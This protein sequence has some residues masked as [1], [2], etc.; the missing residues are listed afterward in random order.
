MEFQT[1]GRVFL[2]Y[3]LIY[4]SKSNEV[5]HSP[6][7]GFVVE[8]TIPFFSTQGEIF[9]SLVH[10]FPDYWNLYNRSVHCGGKD[11]Y[12]QIRQMYNTIVSELPEEYESTLNGMDQTKQ[13]RWILP[14]LSIGSLVTSI[15]STYEVSQIRGSV[16][17]LKNAIKE[18]WDSIEGIEESLKVIDGEFGNV[19]RIM[20]DLSDS[21]TLMSQE[22]SCAINETQTTLSMIMSLL[23]SGPLDVRRVTGDALSGKITTS[24]LPWSQWTKMIKS[25]LALRGTVYESAPHLAYELGRFFV[26]RIERSGLYISGILILPRFHPDKVGE[27]YQAWAVPFDSDHNVVTFPPAIGI[28]SVTGKIYDLDEY[29]CSK[30]PG[31]YLCPSD[32]VREIHIP[33]INQIISGAVKDT[34]CELPISSLETTYPVLQT[35]TGVLMQG[36]L[37]DVVRLRVTGLTN[38]ITQ[39][40]KEKRISQFFGLRDADYIIYRGVQFPIKREA[41]EIQHTQVVL[42]KVTGV[43]PTLI[44]HHY[45]RVSAMKVPKMKHSITGYDPS[46]YWHLG[47]LYVFIISTILLNVW[48]IF[49]RRRNICRKKE[50]GEIA[51]SSPLC[52]ISDLH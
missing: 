40:V 1:L 25:D 51:T 39:T 16:S 42:D 24:L 36:N 15:W 34:D 3:L 46:I 20:N 38:I 23:A 26:S 33:C 44:S 50:R 43:P 8:K 17:A 28:S 7:Y 10:K 6:E 12:Q 45:D 21:I 19:Y 14:F 4:E 37:T 5:Y 49:L 2:C 41:L 11:L 9:L 48:N 13:K 52:V 47:I 22:I 18:Q 32:R 29:S 35:A 31:F 27:V 30:K